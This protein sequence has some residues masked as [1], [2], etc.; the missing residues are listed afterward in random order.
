MIKYARYNVQESTYNNRSPRTC[1][2]VSKIRSV[3]Y[4][5]PGPI[6]YEVHTRYTEEWSQE[7]CSL[8]NLGHIVAVPLRRSLSYASSFLGTFCTER[9]E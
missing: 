4:P 7:Y 5:Y 9:Q 1:S 2:C 6:D 3:T 8:F